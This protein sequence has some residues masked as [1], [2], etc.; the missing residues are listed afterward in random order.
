MASKNSKMRSF[1]DQQVSTRNFELMF[2][3]RRFERMLLTMF[4]WSNLP[5]GISERFLETS[6]YL[7]G[8][9][10]MYKNAAGFYVVRNAVANGLNAYEEPTSYTTFTASGTQADLLPS[11]TI[12]ADDCV[13]IWNNYQRQ[14]D[15]SNVDFYARKLQNIEMTI[16][17]N[18]EQLKQPYI[19]GCDEGQKETVTQIMKKKTNGEPII[20]VNNMSA[21][22]IDFNIFDLKINDHTSDLMDLKH[23]YIN[24]ALTFFG[25][26]NVTVIKKERLVSGEAS[27]NDE[28]ILLMRNARF[29]TRL[30]AVEEMAKK[31]TDIEPVTCEFN[32]EKLRE[33]IVEM[34]GDKGGE[35]NE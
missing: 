31:F 25:V 15:Y 14:G 34:T 20:M 8:F 18:L 23:E 17:E 32:I 21:R 2:Y 27:Q 5:D 7:H 24:E 11:E 29:K 26:N 35:D 6:L 13:V 9:V 33:N 10:I 22:G 16:T 12:D 1:A 19:I 30:E 4:D 28:Q 3:R